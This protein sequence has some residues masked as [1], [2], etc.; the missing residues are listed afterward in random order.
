MVR[1]PF[2]VRT[3]FRADRDA[4]GAGLWRARTEIGL[5]LGGAL[6][7]Q[8]GRRREEGA[9]RRDR[10]PR[11]GPGYDA[12]SSAAEISRR[13][14]LGRKLRRRQVAELASRTGL[15]DPRHLECASPSRSGAF[16]RRPRRQGGTVPARPRGR[17]WPAGSAYAVGGT[18][19]AAT[20]PTVAACSRICAELGLQTL[21]LLVGQVE[22]GEAGDVLDVDLDRHDAE[23]SGGPERAG[24]PTVAPRSR[25][26]RNRVSASR[27]R[28][29]PSASTR[30]RWEPQ[31]RVCEPR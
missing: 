17:R 9:D 18:S 11:C 4:G 24:Q 30:S 22:A 5:E 29:R 31:V 6:A 20:S 19:S 28:A 7:R 3:S 25:P 12:A 2:V 8:L 14:E 27:A 16:A 23:C 26:R 21:L 10:P 1:I 15:R 13:R